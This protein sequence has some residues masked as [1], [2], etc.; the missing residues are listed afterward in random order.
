M[1]VKDL[2]NTHERVKIL[3]QHVWPN[4]S[5]CDELER[6]HQGELSCENAQIWSYEIFCGT[7]G[8]GEPVEVSQISSVADIGDGTRLKTREDFS[9][10]WKLCNSLSSS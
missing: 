9:S 3:H 5:G 4:I 1:M 8:L 2:S 10:F 7:N 6:Q